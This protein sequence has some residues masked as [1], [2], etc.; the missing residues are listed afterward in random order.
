MSNIFKDILQ[1][2]AA[3]AS[4]RLIVTPFF[5]GGDDEPLF[6]TDEPLKGTVFEDYKPPSNLP[7]GTEVDAK[8]K[9]IGRYGGAFL[10]SEL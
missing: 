8:G 4:K 9:P 2:E 7:P 10:D 3:K 6:S 5:G 1:S